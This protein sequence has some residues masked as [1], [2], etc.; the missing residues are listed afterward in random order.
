M[1]I[2]FL[3]FVCLSVAVNLASALTGEHFA[4]VYLFSI[5]SFIFF[6]WMF[7]PSLSRYYT[8]YEK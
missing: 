4:Y 3:S 7:V 8:V 2:L 1:K 6:L 5:L